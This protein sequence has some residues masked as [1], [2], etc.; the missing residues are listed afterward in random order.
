MAFPTRV[1]SSEPNSYYD[2]WHDTAV[3]DTSLF[4]TPE[5]SAHHI[6]YNAPLVLNTFCWDNLAVFRCP[7]QNMFDTKL[8]DF[9]LF[10]F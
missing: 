9:Y 4:L 2:N 1:H 10:P 6:L 7:H 3:Q 8:N 5:A